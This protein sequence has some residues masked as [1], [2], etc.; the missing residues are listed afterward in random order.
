[1]TGGEAAGDNTYNDDAKDREEFCAKS[2]PRSEDTNELK[3]QSL[4]DIYWV[5]EEILV[6]LYISLI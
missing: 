2:P 4:A 6:F 3:D 1:L 5:L